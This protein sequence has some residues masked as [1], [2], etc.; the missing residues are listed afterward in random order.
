MAAA[1][2]DERTFA[3]CTTAAAA[4]RI[5]TGPGDIHEYFLALACCLICWR[6]LETTPG[7]ISER[8]APAAFEEQSAVTRMQPGVR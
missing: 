6:R 1:E 8:T 3:G 4:L 7:S 5:R 2:C